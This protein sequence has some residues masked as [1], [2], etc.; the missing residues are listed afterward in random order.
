[1]A[2]YGMSL[3]AMG[4]CGTMALSLRLGKT[5]N[6]P[7]QT[8]RPRVSFGDWVDGSVYKLV[9]EWFGFFFVFFFLFA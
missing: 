2:S 9:I 1:M 6:L 8:L 7:T 4:I 5:L 3:T